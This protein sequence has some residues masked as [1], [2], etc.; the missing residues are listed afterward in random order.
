MTRDW[1]SSKSTAKRGHM[2]RSSRS[3]KQA[4][5]QRLTHFEE[6]YSVYDAEIARIEASRCIQCPDPA[7]CQLACPLGND[8]PTALRLIE[9]AVS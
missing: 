6:I 8:I 4:A 5:D 3:R 1:A 9:E 2:P 7:P